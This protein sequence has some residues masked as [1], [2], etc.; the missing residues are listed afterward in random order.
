M[1]PKVTQ[2]L[3]DRDRLQIQ[4]LSTVLQGLG[5]RTSLGLILRD[6]ESLMVGW[7]GRGE[8]VVEAG[9]A[10]AGSRTSHHP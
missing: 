10:H 4:G 5:V 1:F 9:A 3:S 8:E 7:D 6:S 2:T